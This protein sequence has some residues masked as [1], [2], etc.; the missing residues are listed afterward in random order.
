MLG[1]VAEAAPG[2]RA[3]ATTVAA[4]AHPYTLQ[5]DFT[6]AAAEFHVPVSVLLAVSYQETLWESHQG[7][8]S[9]T[10]NFNVM[11][12]TQVTASEV[13]PA[14]TAQKK[15][16]LN[17]WGDGRKHPAPS[18]KALATVDTVDTAAPALHTLDAAAALVKEPA[19]QLRSSMEQSVRGGAALLASYERKLAGSLPADPG[20]WFGAVAEYDQAPDAATADQFAGRVYATM[21]SGATRTTDD[22][23]TVTLAAAPSVLPQTGQVHALGLPGSS[24][25]AAAAA[26]PDVPKGM[27]CSYDFSLVN[28]DGYDDADRPTDGDAI[29]YIILHDAE[30]SASTAVQTIED[31]PYAAHFVVAASGAVTQM[32][33]VKDTGI[34]ADNKTVNMHSIGIENEGYALT[35]PSGGSSWFSEQEYESAAALTKYLAGVYDIPLDRDHVIG[36]DDSP[37]AITSTVAEQHFDPGVYWDW[38]NFLG[39][40]GAPLS[41]NGQAVVG[42]TV[43]IAPPYTS[44]NEPLVTGCQ[45]LAYKPTAC[46]VQPANFVYLRTSP[47]ASAPLITDSL[48]TQSGMTP[49]TTDGADVSDKAVYGQTFV[50]A[51]L[52]GDWTAIWYGGQKAWFYN[53]GGVNAYANASST[54]LVVTPVSGKTSIPVYGRAYPEASAY[55]AVLQTPAEQAS[56]QLTITPL[57]DYSIPAGQAYTADAEVA[58]DYYSFEDINPGD[59][60][61]ST[62]SDCVEVIGNTQY[63]PIR[64]NHRLA[65]VMASDVQVIA[66]TTPPVGTYTPV[67]PSRILDTRYGTGAPKAPVGAGKAVSLQIAGQPGVPATG[68]TAV[69]LNVTATDAT[70]SGFVQAYPDGQGRPSVGSNL[71]FTKGETIPNLV[72]VQVGTDGKVDLYNSAGTTD[73]IAD[74]NGYYTANGSGS[75]LVPVG[76]SRILDT[77]YGTGA[78]KAPVG[79]GKAVSLQIAGQPGVPATGV[80]AV[81]LNVTATDTTAGGHVSV[82]PDGS[83]LPPVSNLNFTQGETIPNLVIVQ[84]GTDGKVDLYNSAG[85]TDLI[86]DISGYYTADGSGSVFHTAGP[87]RVMD[88]R[89][90]IGVRTGAVGP[91]GTVTLQVGAHNGVPLKAT[92]VVLNVT[93][94]APTAGGHLTVYP[95]G[96]AQPAVSNLNFTQGET[97]ANLVVVPVVDGKVVFGNAFGDTQVIADL[98]GYYTQ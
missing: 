3:V 85:T 61:C 96:S 59:A 20:A 90:G 46:P 10:G 69:V 18:A 47:S 53:P 58:G 91:G 14:T 81:V 54:Q 92:A 40:V 12:L 8:P 15:A 49:G 60:T 48:L 44:A 29:R 45:T 11:G 71:N 70:G 7:H 17:A 51:Q 95:D 83:A 72:I 13:V 33:P 23:Q 76:P 21:R 16:D 30:G 43:T 89:S 31:G 93:V 38:S 9:S 66:P 39:L 55:P 65:F 24:A 35:L 25:P 52:S 34:H 79:A 94:T 19:A 5:A 82:Y 84:V 78:P 74:V 26:C 42:G 41:G 86:A 73:L 56:L 97:I 2:T 77:R 80:T 28:P 36:H 63:Y 75:K 98:M 6:S 64:Y 88:T 62:P 32:L 57:A 68:V 22:G 37:Y 87:V 4:D 67:S 27:A 1:A 50:V